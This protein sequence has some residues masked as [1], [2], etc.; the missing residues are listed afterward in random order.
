MPTATRTA[1][2]WS[3]ARVRRGL[4]RRRAAAASGA[5]VI[6]CDE[7]AELGGRCCS[8]PLPIPTPRSTASPR[9]LAARARSRLLRRTPRV[10]LLTRTT[11]FGYFPHNLLGLNQRLT[12]HLAR[13]DRAAS[14]ASGYGRCGRKEVV[15]ATGAIERPLVFPGNDRPGILLAAAAAHLS[16]T[17]TACSSGSRVVIVTA[18]D[19]AYQAAL[20]LHRAGVDGRGHRRRA[21]AAPP[22]GAL[23]DAARRAGLPIATQRPCSARPAAARPRDPRR[24]GWMPPAAG[25]SGAANSTA[26]WCSMSGGFTP[27]VH[28]FSQ[29]RGKLA[30]D[31]SAAAPSCPAQAAERV[32]SAGAC[33]GR[34]LAR[35]PRCGTARR[36]GAAAA[37]ARGLAGRASQPPMPPPESSAAG[38]PRRAPHSRPARERRKAFVD[39]QNDV[40]VARPHARGPRRLPLDRAREALHDHRDGDR[41]GQDLQPQR[42]RDRRA[43]SSARRCRRSG[44]RRSAC[45]TRP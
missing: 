16:A 22:S 29:S 43:R 8:E 2:C 39:W 44:S 27:S 14:R 37:R 10:T 1:T 24:R 20:D 35:A 4:R 6:L 40:T 7:Q 23:P 13:P 12:D 11:A 25:R 3:S 33:R 32:R 21:C 30:W 38:M 5:R 34:V 26:T 17:V 42:A 19:A 28:L 15:L 36:R 45:P 31:E 9:S 41:P 18:C